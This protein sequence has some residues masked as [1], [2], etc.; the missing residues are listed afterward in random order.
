MRNRLEN[1]LFVSRIVALRAGGP[2][3]SVLR[4]RNT[5]SLG[6]RDMVRPLRHEWQQTMVAVWGRLT[7]SL[8]E[9]SVVSLSSVMSL[10]TWPV[11][12]CETFVVSPPTRRSD[13]DADEFKLH[14]QH[15]Y[16]LKIKKLVGEAWVIPSKNQILF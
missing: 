3:V 4:H 5:D 14:R 6:R 9:R 11:W 1:V 12:D 10:T 8:R 15:R 16:A 7:E 2:E 13:A